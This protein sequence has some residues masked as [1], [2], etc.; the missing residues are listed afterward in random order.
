MSVEIIGLDV[1]AIVISQFRGSLLEDAR[2]NVGEISGEAT[3]NQELWIVER[4]GEIWKAHIAE[5]QDP[6]ELILRA[7]QELNLPIV[8][9]IVPDSDSKLFFQ[10]PAYIAA[11]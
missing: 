7:T 8:F 11:I 6:A 4:G 9:L 1:N 10:A 3:A 2:G 5:P